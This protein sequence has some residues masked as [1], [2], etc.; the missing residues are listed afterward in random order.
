MYVTTKFINKKPE[1]PLVKKASSSTDAS[2]TPAHSKHNSHNN[3]HVSANRAIGIE[4]KKHPGCNIQYL[5][6]DCFD[7]NESDFYLCSECSKCHK[8]RLT[9]IWNAGEKVCRLN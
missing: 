3:L 7:R 6:E 1:P 2:K 5:C 4:C 8:H 9:N